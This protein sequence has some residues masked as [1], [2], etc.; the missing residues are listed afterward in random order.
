M[1]HPD[2][3]GAGAEKASG[4]DQRGAM[5]RR[6]LIGTPG[7]EAALGA[8]VPATLD[9]RVDDR[10]P[11]MVTA[12]EPDDDVSVSVGAGAAPL[13][14]VFA[15]Q[16]LPAAVAVAAPSIARAADAAYAEVEAAVDAAS[17][18]FT[19][20]AFALTGA[21]GGLASRATLIATEL[22]ARLRQRRRRASRGYRPPEEAAAHFA[23]MA[24]VIQLL[25]TE[26]EHLWV[27]TARPHRLAGGGG[28][29]T[30]WPGGVA[31]V[32]EDRRPPSRAYRKLE[33]AL[34]WMDEAPTAGQ[35]CV[36]LGAAPGGWT[37]VALSRGA[38]VIAVDRAALE[39]PVRGHRALTMVEGNAFTYEPPPARR[40]VD[41]L[42]CDVICEP[43]RTVELLRRWLGTSGGPWCR[44]L[45]VTVKFK[46]QS[47]Y[48]AVIDDVRAALLAA[49]CRRWRIKHLHHNK[50]EVTVMAAVR[51]S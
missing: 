9:P 23:D 3:A 51:A 43:A 18:P 42:L 30:P 40:P 39:P 24:L 26:R 50:N 21:D 16:Q 47:G 13:D 31:P 20:H 4:A 1:P 44:R 5:R 41:W 36:D 14:P 28:T 32:A 8:E 7:F 25:A 11:G 19:I 6:L 22:L 49:G 37:H 46:G 27:S 45:V 12:R 33:E 34:L 29:V 2:G 38:R 48:T 35:I 17:G 15:R 10:W